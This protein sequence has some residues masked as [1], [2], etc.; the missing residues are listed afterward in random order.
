MTPRAGDGH[1]ANSVF[2]TQL[3]VDV[4]LTEMRQA[5]A[6]LCWC[7]THGLSLGAPTLTNKPIQQ[8]Q[9]MLD[10]HDHRLAGNNSSAVAVSF[11]TPRHMII[12][13]STEKKNVPWQKNIYIKYT[14]TIL[15]MVLINLTL[16]ESSLWFEYYNSY[17]FWSTCT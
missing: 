12:L 3:C 1:K 16:W 17:Q 13:W 7:L 2:S 14:H 6:W 9:N 15:E 5:A 4:L 10:R 8:A 11:P